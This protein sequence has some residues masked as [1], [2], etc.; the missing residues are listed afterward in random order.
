MTA[1]HIDFLGEI[2]PL[3]PDKPL[4]IGRDAD[5][6]IDDN[7]YLHRRFLEV[8]LRD[9]MVWVS[10]VGTSLT[11]TLADADGL[12]QAWLAPGARLPVVFERTAVWFTAGPTTYELDI[13][14]GQSAFTPS[15]PLGR[16]VGET[17]IGRLSFTPDQKLLILALGEDIL[18]RGNRG[19]GR[20]PANADAAARLGWTITK[21][22]RK[23][24]NVC[25]KLTRLGIRGLH[26]GAEKLATNRRARLVEYAVATRLIV[27]NDLQLLD[28]VT[29]N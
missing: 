20:I 2:Y 22:N 17:T 10:N 29:L 23:L 25:E 27:P 24:D 21:F 8:E 28:T 13:L 12:L 1:P 9:S 19:T 16:D 6:V 5:I 15:T 4:V 26:G 7:P 14:A 18:K 11:A 3:E